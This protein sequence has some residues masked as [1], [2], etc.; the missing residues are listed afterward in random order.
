MNYIYIYIY[1]HQKVL[2]GLTC[3]NFFYYIYLYFAFC[4]KFW[5]K[6]HYYDIF[7]WG[8]FVYSINE[9]EKENMTVIFVS[10]LSGISKILLRHICLVHFQKIILLGV[11][12]ITNIPNIYWKRHRG[13]GL[14]SA[15]YKRCQKWN[16]LLFCVSE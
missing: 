9:K 1:I 14:E 7:Q 8:M 6:I 15:S 16:L 3:T 2:K 10:N 11:R 13:F 12:P 5:F 4:N